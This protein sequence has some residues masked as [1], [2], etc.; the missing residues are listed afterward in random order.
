MPPMAELPLAHA[1]W[2]LKHGLKPSQEQPDERPFSELDIID[3]LGRRRKSTQ[4][5]HIVS[6]RATL[7]AVRR[8]SVRTI[9]DQSTGVLFDAQSLKAWL[10]PI[11]YVILDGDKPLYVGR[12]RQGL[13]RVFSAHHKGHLFAGHDLMVWSVPSIEAMKKLEELLIE[14]LKPPHN[15]RYLGHAQRLRD[16]TGLSI[17]Q[18]RAVVKDL[19]EAAGG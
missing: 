19:R 5:G 13:R 9:L 7:D 14:G 17:T 11:V 3:L 15:A 6:D 8:E 4:S 1:S 10:G 12:S 2:R 18:A 16:L